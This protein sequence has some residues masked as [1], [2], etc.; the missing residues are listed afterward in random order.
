MEEFHFDLNGYVLL[1]GAISDAE[2][3][4]IN[5]AL[6][7]LPKMKLGDWLG[8][9]HMTAGPGDI[10]LQQV[11]ELGPAFER[12]ID[13]PAY[14]EKL[15]RFIGGNGW[16]NQHNGLLTIDEAFANFRATGGGIP[17]HGSGGADGT[18]EQ[19]PSMKATYRF[20]NDT[21]RHH[22]CPSVLGSR[23]EPGVWAVPQFM[24][25]QINMALALSDIG[26]GDG[27]TMLLPGE[28][29]TCHRLRQVPNSLGLHVTVADPPHNRAPLGA[30]ARTKPMCLG[31][32]R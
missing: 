22:R 32:P 10:S 28:Q 7:E 19:Q 30:Q 13:H 14:F 27:A 5:R 21:V 6:D 2:V 18:K 12:L 31:R 3:A 15:K 16:D 24:S 17:M 23:P 11:Y 1:R 25:G 4:S 26:D 9:A 29:R 8:H 20:A